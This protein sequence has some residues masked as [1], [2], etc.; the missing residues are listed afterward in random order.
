ML[1]LRNDVNNIFE[2]IEQKKQL[3]IYGAGASSKLLLQTYFHKGLKEKLA[4]IVDRN[5]QLDGTFL[6]VNQ[7]IRVKIVSLK[8]FCAEY[9][10]KLKDFN[11]LITPYTALKIVMSLDI[12]EELN[13]MD[14]YIYSL[15][16]NKNKPYS[17][18][19][20][21]TDKP[22][23][24]K[25]IHYFWIGGNPLLEE[26]KQNIESWRKYAPDYE[27]IEWNESNY[28]FSSHPY[29]YEALK[30]KQY[31]Y[32]TDY[33]RKDILY[34]YGGIYLDTDVELVGSL[35]DLLYNEVF[36]GIDDG[37]Q[38]NSGS[39]LGAVQGSRVIKTF[40]ELY[41]GV[42][43]VNPDGSFNY[44]YNTYYETQYMIDRGFELKNEFQMI[45]GVS[46]FPREVFMP[47]GF[48]GVEDDYTVRTVANHKINP[49]DKTNVRKILE[50][51]K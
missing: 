27:I 21:T 43:F 38:L 49:Y 10:S 35:D 41:D 12:I 47:E 18:S 45:D 31:M 11:M 28:D 9:V 48:I 13:G 15:I 46:C 30:H 1:N 42:N 16:V 24:P 44:K 36:V 3:I 5:E 40:M 2:L 39:G 50:R 23:I 20:R 32:A 26:Y 34:R 6:E 33:A 25:K 4:F 14:T 29:M 7:D 37:A 19:L 22:L 51:I 8:S 17:F